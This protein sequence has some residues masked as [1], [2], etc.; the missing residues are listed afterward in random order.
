MA[1][2]PSSRWRSAPAN[3]L[4]TRCG[5][6]GAAWACL[7]TSKWTTSWS[8]TAAPPLRGDWHIIAPD[9]RGHGDSQWSP[10]GSYTMAGYIYVLA[11]LSHQLRLGPVTIFAHCLGGYFALRFA[12]FLP[13]AVAWV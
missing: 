8:S 7:A 9:L 1:T 3:T 10:D 4:S 5:R 12:G 11:Q 2:V 13:V 6:P